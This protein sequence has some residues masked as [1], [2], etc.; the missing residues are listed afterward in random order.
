MRNMLYKELMGDFQRYYEKPYEDMSN[1][2]GQ[3]INITT[4]NCVE[5]IFSIYSKLTE[6]LPLKFLTFSR[7]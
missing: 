2:L 7:K 4:P 5:G 3:I 6:I 1:L